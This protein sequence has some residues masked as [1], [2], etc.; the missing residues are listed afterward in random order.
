MSTLRLPSKPA[1]GA[2]RA[3]AF[4][5]HTIVPARPDQAHPGD[6]KMGRSSAFE[7]HRRAGVWL[8]VTIGI[9]Y[10]EPG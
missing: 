3:L 10:G 7:R 8:H 4:P 2:I 1:G 9:G 6:H 5:A